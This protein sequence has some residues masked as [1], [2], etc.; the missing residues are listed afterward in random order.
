[1]IRE[2]HKGWDPLRNGILNPTKTPGAS[3]SWHN[4]ESTQIKTAA[5]WAY[6]QFSLLQFPLC[7]STSMTHVLQGLEGGGG[8]VAHTDNL[9]QTDTVRVYHT[10]CPVQRVGLMKRSEGRAFGSTQEKRLI[11]QNFTSL[12]SLPC[13]HCCATFGGMGTCDHV[14]CMSNTQLIALGT[15]KNKQKGKSNIPVTICWS[16]QAI[17]SA[18][19]SRTLHVKLRLCVILTSKG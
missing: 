16:K 15:E 9:T 10:S 19:Q 13:L 3:L 1:M 2:R 17:N 14:I 6:P 8:G 18:L 5:L 12:Q 7:W 11:S 4:L